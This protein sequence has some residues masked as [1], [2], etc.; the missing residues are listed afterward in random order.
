MKDEC[1][2]C[3]YVHLK[4]FP[5]AA[6]LIAVNRA[7]FTVEA[8]CRRWAPRPGVPFED[9]F[10]RVLIDDC[11]GEYQTDLVDGGDDDGR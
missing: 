5:D 10:P 7:P 4:Y 2:I 8:N 1:I 9:R 11:C 3:K 6:K